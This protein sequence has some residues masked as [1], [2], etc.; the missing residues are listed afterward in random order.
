MLF[1]QI[2]GR[3]ASQSAFVGFLFQSLLD[4]SGKQTQNKQIASFVSRVKPKFDERQSVFN[5]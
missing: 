1:T 2:S 4:L 5:I 3:N